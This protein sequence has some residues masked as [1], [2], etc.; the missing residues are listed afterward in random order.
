MSKERL[1][2]LL[3][4]ALM[5]FARDEYEKENVLDGL[6]M[7]EEEFIEIT[8]EFNEKI[9]F[10]ADKNCYLGH[11]E[12]CGEPIFETDQYAIIDGNY[13]CD[14]CGGEDGLSISE[15]EEQENEDY[16]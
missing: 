10:F 13:Y 9:E 8:S 3:F 5:K 4:N 14:Y 11:C 12:C 16:E 15:L 1:K 7:S 2:E 6:E